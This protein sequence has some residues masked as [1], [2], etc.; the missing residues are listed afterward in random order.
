[1]N[2][3]HATTEP[4][5]LQRLKQLLRSSTR[6]AEIDARVARLYGLAAE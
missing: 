5:L 2:V 1:M 3:L 4:N 6:E